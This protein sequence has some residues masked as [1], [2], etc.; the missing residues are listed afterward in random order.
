MDMT[1]NPGFES[2]DRR[3][4]QAG[5]CAAAIAA[6]QHSY[7]ELVAGQTGLISEAEIQPVA[8]LP[9]LEESTRPNAADPALVGQVAILKLNGGLGTSMG[10]E[11]AKSLLAVKNGLTFLDF[12]ARQILHLRR[13]Y[14]VPLH[15]L[16]MNSF[17][18]SRQTLEYLARYPEL[19]PAAKLELMQNQ[20]PKVDARTLQPALWPENPLLEWCPPGHGDLYPS[21]LDSGLLEQLL[22]QGVKYLFVSNS[23]N[24]GAN[25][26]L[27]LLD[28]FARS[29]KSFLM[30]VAERTAS[31]RKGGHLAQKNG[32]LLL[33]E[34]AQC[35]KADEPAFQDIQ[36]H[37]FFN[38]NN[39]WVRL[40]SLKELLR[41]HG[42]FLPLPLIKNAKT[43][44]PRQKESPP[45]FQLETA[46]G[47]AIAIFD[48][49]G[50]IVVPRAR[51]APVKTCADLLAL[52]SDAYAVTEDWRITLCHTED[53]PP[54]AVE[55]DPVHY[56]LVDQL[57]EKLAGG[58]PS[59]K[60]CRELVI[61]GPVQ[62]NS[63]NVFR[64]KVMVKNQSGEP[65]AL[66]PGEYQDCVQE[67][68]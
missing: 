34:S 6:F 65:K 53:G 14:R 31:D 57:D 18:T 39:L 7:Q 11:Q 19:G 58:V 46:M 25:L 36:R 41:R 30:E 27:G 1:N 43:V 17:S 59:L 3:M 45:V 33:R 29:G 68:T 26:D 37:R 51:F 12:I 54:P 56:K 60:A 62:L 32:R 9:R 16:L 47:A 52:R 4:R 38:T 5:V 21:L 44:D 40:E 35:P 8:E 13:Q 28:Y 61:Q 15:F 2:F 50:A 22:A 48:H 23:D 10:L 63:G 66:M 64:G 24:L 67:L 55:L 49:A 42:G 20:V